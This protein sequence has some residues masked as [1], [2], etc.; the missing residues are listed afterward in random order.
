MD[1]AI[2]GEFVGSLEVRDQDGSASEDLA[3]V[4]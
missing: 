1:R 3:T 4:E 2:F